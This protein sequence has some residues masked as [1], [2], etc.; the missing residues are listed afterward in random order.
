MFYSHY[1]LNG[2]AEIPGNIFFWIN[3]IYNAVKVGFLNF[4]SHK[5]I[6]SY[7]YI[8]QNFQNLS[9]SVH[10]MSYVPNKNCILIAYNQIIKNLSASLNFWCEYD[11]EQDMSPLD[12]LKLTSCL[13]N[14]T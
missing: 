7:R 10:I 11:W 5:T 2:K 3:L 13:L 4:I 1:F 6:I 14:I 9:Q 8:F 12:S